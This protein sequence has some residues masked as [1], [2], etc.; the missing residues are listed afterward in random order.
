MPKPPTSVRVFFLEKTPYIQQAVL[1]SE[2]LVYNQV[3][4]EYV[5]FIVF[6]DFVPSQETYVLS[7]PD[8]ETEIS[9]C[10]TLG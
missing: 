7:I 6:Y 5:E 3:I 9:S 4:D 2:I 8:Y 10:D 1:I